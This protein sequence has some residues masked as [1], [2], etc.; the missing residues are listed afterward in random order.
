M[1]NSHIY[2]ENH[3]RF[4]R[5][6]SIVNI[7]FIMHIISDMMCSAMP[8]ISPY[9]L[10]FITYAYFLQLFEIIPPYF[11]IHKRHGKTGTQNM[12]HIIGSVVSAG[13]QKPLFFVEFTI[14][15]P[16]SGYIID[17]IIPAGAHIVENHVPI[18]CLPFVGIVMNAEIVFPGGNNGRK[19]G[20][21]NTAL[22][23]GIIKFCFILVLIHAVT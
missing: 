3:A 8:D 12:K 14:D 5:P 7:D 16:A 22:C 13:I 23:Q 11:L 9:I 10:K 21:K 17:F 20:R 1:V 15:G 18:M 19:A 6:A 4:Q 2:T